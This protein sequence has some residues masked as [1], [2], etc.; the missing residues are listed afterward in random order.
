MRAVTLRE[1]ECGKALIERVL[2]DAERDGGLILPS[3]A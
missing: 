2:K 1:E 3:C